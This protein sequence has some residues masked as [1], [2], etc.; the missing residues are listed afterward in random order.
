[1]HRGII[2]G[3]G[4]KH[5]VYVYLYAK[6]DRENIDDNELEAFRELAELYAQKSDTD[7]EKEL[8]SGVLVEICR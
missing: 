2:L 3:K 6:K 7:V 4:G 5:W 1:M 8:D